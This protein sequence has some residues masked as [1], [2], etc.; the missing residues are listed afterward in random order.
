M[1]CDFKNQNTSH[2]VT[3]LKLIKYYL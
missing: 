3:S 2:S 1:Y